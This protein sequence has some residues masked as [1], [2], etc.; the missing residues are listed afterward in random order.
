M[1]VP[2]A[3]RS[4]QRPAVHV[5]PPAREVPDLAGDVRATLLQPPR[6]L[7]PK[8]F[9]DERGSR[10]FDAICDTP[11]YYPTRVEQ[12]LLRASAP[13]VIEAAHP[14][15]VLELGSGTCRKT[16]ELLA[17]CGRA[18]H[19]VCFWPF[20]VC[21][22]V[23]RESARWLVHELPWLSVQGLVGD[24]HAGLSHLPRPDGPCLYLFLGGTLGNFEPDEADTFM[25]ELAA[26]MR[27]GD[28]LLLGV[29]RVKNPAVLEAAY[30]DAA[31]ITA[32]FNRNVLHV[33]NRELGA[34]FNVPAFAHRAFYDPAHERIEMHLVATEAQQVHFAALDE[35][36]TLAACE[37]IRTE[38]SRKFTP[39]SLDAL[40]R[41][42]GLRRSHHFEADGGAYSLVLA[43]P[44]N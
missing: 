13:Q 16:F 14:A 15:H 24:Y 38:I 5:V 27:P 3:R 37:S 35:Q 21:E 17:A 44:A 2:E 40:L 10:L 33:L 11:E 28:Q 12:A 6:W 8:Y 18:G 30:N 7:P 41:R 42:A 26:H 36:I 19:E 9:Y 4:G 25:T 23:V 31:G 29:D 22:E 34:D 43:T 39:Q 20:D 32:E 1:P